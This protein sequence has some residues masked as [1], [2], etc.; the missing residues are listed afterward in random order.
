MKN[1]FETIVAKSLENLFYER[2]IFHSEADFH[3]ALAMKIAENKNIKIRLEKPCTISEDK[4]IKIDIE[5]T[6]NDGEKDLKYAIELKYKTKELNCVYLGENFNLKAH[7]DRNLGRYD[8]WK[9]CERITKLENFCGGCVIFL[10]N[11]GLYKNTTN[12]LNCM[13]KNF[14]IDKESL[15]NKNL[16][17][18]SSREKKEISKEDLKKSVGNNRTSEITLGEKVLLGEWGEQKKTDDNNRNEIKFYH[19]I[20]KIDLLK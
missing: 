11:D 17:W 12:D 10:T 8:F 16:N 4:Q 2:F 9:D 15:K 14:A 5:L 18:I 7:S 1:E 20:A 19:I 3:H 13:S 6:A